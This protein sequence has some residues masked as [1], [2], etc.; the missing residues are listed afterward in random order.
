MRLRLSLLVLILA[1]LACNTL[2]PPATPALR[3][4][5]TRFPTE[6]VLEPS[7]EAPGATLTPDQSALPAGVRACAFVPGISVPASMPDEVVN[8]PAPTPHPTAAPPAITQVEAQTTERQL[9]VYQE[10]WDAVNENYV[11]EDFRGQ[12]WDAIGQRYKA[13]I[14]QGLSDEDFYLAMGQMVWD[15]GDEHSGFEDPQQVAETEAQMRGQNDYVGVG[16]LHSPLMEAGRSVVITTFPGSPAEAGGIRMH[17]SIVAVDGE[18]VASIFEKDEPLSGRI[19]GVEGTPVTLTIERPGQGTFDVTLT[20]RRITG[21]LPINYCLM[22]KER[23]GYIF[24]PGL[25]DETIPLQIRDALEALTSAGPLNGLVIDNRMNGG[26]LLSAMNDVLSYFTD[27]VQGYF[28]SR[29]SREPLEIRAD[30]VNGSQTLPL[31]VL[32]S[33]ETVS[34]GEIMSGILRVSGR[35]TIIGET[36][37]GNVEVLWGFD[38]EDGSRAWIASST[39]EPVGA[40]NGVWEDTGIIADI[41]A[42]SRWDLFTEASDPGLAAAVEFLTTNR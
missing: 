13:L 37:L 7:A 39:F 38:F 27:G 20:R 18:T 6:A 19:R 10:L 23:L 41:V 17:D 29:Q 5:A 11:Y 22:P 24:I 33:K 25:E 4:T 31:A 42:P 12:D 8:P 14:E 16:I 21:A 30:D 2:L 28:V 32:V 1:S 36:T 40:A 26:G 34:A 15:L 35:A 9:R 3:P